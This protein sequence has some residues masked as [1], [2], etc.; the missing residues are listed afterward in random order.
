MNIDNLIEDSSIFLN[1]LKI[2]SL[3]SIPAPPSKK[4]ILTRAYKTFP[5]FPKSL[6]EFYTRHDGLRFEW[7]HEAGNVYSGKIML[8]SVDFLLGGRTGE[9][10][11]H[12]FEDIIWNTEEE[13]SETLSLKKKLKIL[14]NNSSQQ[15][16][17][18]I[19]LSSSGTPLY[20]MQDSELF[21]ISLSIDVYIDTAFQFLGMTY[22]QHIFTPDGNKGKSGL[23]NKC[24]NQLKTILPEQRF[25]E[26]FKRAK[27]Q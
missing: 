9:W 24:L 4:K 5:L 1:T 18:L 23:G 6:L 17:V 25:Q 15:I 16:F 8:S 20:L 13:D 11:E 27:Q 26:I 19:D 22:W 7:F 3:K 12:A 14:D 21:P 2:D 10:D